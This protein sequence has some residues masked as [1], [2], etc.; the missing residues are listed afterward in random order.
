MPRVKASVSRERELRV[1]SC[2]RAHADKAGDAVISIASVGCAAGLTA[3]QARSALQ[4]LVRAGLIVVIPRNLP[5]GA[6]AE[7]AY[8]LTQKAYGTDD[9]SRA[10]PTEACSLLAEGDLSNGDSFHR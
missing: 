3:I 7:N 4:R 6:S 9:G 8:R 10:V 2:L 1:L 5:N